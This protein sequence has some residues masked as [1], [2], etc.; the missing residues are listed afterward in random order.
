MPA[1]KNA[2]RGSVDKA[3][4]AGL[5]VGIQSL[6]AD[7]Q[8]DREASSGRGVRASHLATWTK[9]HHRALGSN[10]DDLGSTPV[11]PL[12]PAGVIPVAALFKA[13]DY[14]SYANYLASLKSFHLD[15]EHP[16]TEHLEHVGRWTTRSVLRGIG[17]ARQSQPIPLP[18]VMALASRLDPCVKDGPTHPRVAYLLGAIFLLREVELSATRLEHLAFNKGDTTIRWSLY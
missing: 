5:T 7:L 11:L 3:L 4:T 2:R 13:G 8:G 1:I 12:T 9:F 15:F 17:P 18:G 6:I 14:R 10:P 16:W